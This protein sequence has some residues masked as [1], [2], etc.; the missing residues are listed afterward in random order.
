MFFFNP[1]IYIILICLID[2]GFMVFQK[3]T[4]GYLE[5]AIAIENEGRYPEYI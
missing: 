5:S 1:R 2:K 4:N 3:K